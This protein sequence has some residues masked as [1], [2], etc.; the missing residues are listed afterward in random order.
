MFG[1]LVVC[2]PSKFTGGALVLEH[3]N[4][5]KRFEWER[6]CED[7]IQWAAFYGDVVHYIEEVTDGHRIT[8]SYKLYKEP[9]K[10]YASIDYD[11]LNDLKT[12]FET[13]IRNATIGKIL[14]RCC[15]L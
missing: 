1:T 2:L 9:A 7:N 11:M 8:I 15:L 10:H 4:G 13:Q 3:K 5:T 12:K 6:A 14:Y